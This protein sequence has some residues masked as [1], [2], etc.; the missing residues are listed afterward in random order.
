[1]R[2]EEIDEILERFRVEMSGVADELAQ[3]TALED[4]DQDDDR[5]PDLSDR[6]DAALRAWLEDETLA[7][8][9]PEGP[10]GIDAH[11]LNQELL[12]K[13]LAGLK[14]DALRDI[15]NRKKAVPERKLDELTRQVARLYDW[16]PEKIAQLVLD[17]TE[18]P[19]ETEGGLSTRIYT[20]ADPADVTYMANRLDYVDGRYYRTDIAKWFIFDDYK[21]QGPVLRV[22][23]TLQSWKASVDPSSEDKVTSDRDVAASSLVVRDGATTARVVDAKTHAVAKSMLAAFKVATLAEPLAYVPNA[24]TDAPVVASKLH[25]N[26]TFLLD[27]VTHRLRGPLFR[28]KN[29]VLARFKYSNRA[30]VPKVSSKKPSLSAVRFEGENLLDSPGTCSLMWT[31]GRPLVDVTVSVAATVSETDNTIRARVPVRIVLEKD[32]VLVSTGLISDSALGAEVHRSVVAQVE[33][34]IVQGVSPERE[35]RLVRTI[36]AQAEN[37]DPDADAQLLDDPELGDDMDLI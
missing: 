21:V 11:E 32:A 30:G 28:E 22:N 35:A 14:G 33:A 16:D 3:A 36:K 19:H 26:T 5:V 18:E 2:V 23:G 9:E 15:A 7:L 37:P 25:P 1:M 6:A 34:A 10:S 12:K 29:A 17:Y 31:E 20:L 13:A 4:E 24:G 8:V 27:I